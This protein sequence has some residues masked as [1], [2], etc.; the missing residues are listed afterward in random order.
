MGVLTINARLYEDETVKGRL[1]LVT[2]AYH[3]EY[4]YQGDVVAIIF[5][6]NYTFSNG[7]TGPTALLWWRE[8]F[9]K[10]YMG[11]YLAIFVVDNGQGSQAEALDWV[12][13]NT[14]PPADDITSITPQEIADQAPAFFVPLAVGNVTIH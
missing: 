2:T 14:W 12:G 8:S 6:D 9:N 5:Y 11:K 4:K 7:V 1:N 10:P 13:P 3:V